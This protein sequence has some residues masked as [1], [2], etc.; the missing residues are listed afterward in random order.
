MEPEHV[1]EIKD[2]LAP[3]V[4]PFKESIDSL[5]D[6]QKALVRRLDTVETALKRS[7]KGSNG[8]QKDEAAELEAKALRH[9]MRAGQPQE[10]F[11]QFAERHAEYKTLSVGS[12]PDGGFT[13]MPTLSGNV[14]SIVR[15]TSPVRQL[16]SV[17]TI[18][19]DAL[20]IPID[21]DDLEANWVSERETRGTTSTPRI[22][23]QRIPVHEI[24]A[25]P[26]ST[27]QLLDDSSRNQE[28][29]LAQ[30]VGSKFARRENSAFVN[31]TGVTQ[32]RGFM[33]YSFGTGID[34]AGTQTTPGIPPGW[35]TFVSVAS[36]TQASL[37]TGAVGAEKLIDLVHT[38]PAQY[39]S[40]AAFA[41]TRRTIGEVRK[42]KDN[43][44]QFIYQESLTAG[45]PAR[46][47]GFPVAEFADMPEIGTNAYPIAFGNWRDAYRVVDRQGVRVLRDPYTSKPY[48]GFYTTKRVG[49][50]VT[51]FQALAFFKTG[52]GA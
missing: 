18:S 24:E 9:F 42:L 5:A 29:W 3:L 2:A 11:K 41:M 16:A 14:I 12:D 43:A 34:Y 21:T 17:E 31:G 45:Q 13:V 39:R 7:P 20:E 8:E 37:G 23:K 6:G 51:N 32:P 38:V 26:F 33:T 49:G 10:T 28:D 35:G 19:T 25:F 15:E 50:D 22:A 44:G 48:V 1:Q 40:N 46:L 27:Q 52:T 36:G 30:K 4:E 47:L